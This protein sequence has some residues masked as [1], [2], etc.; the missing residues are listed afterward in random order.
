MPDGELIL[1]QTEDG[2]ARVQ[3]RAADGTVWLTQAEIAELFNVTPQNV[4]QHLRSLY[5]DGEVTEAA[6]C[7][8]YLQVRRE[9]DRD[10]Q[11]SLR[12]YNLDAILGIGY[13]VRSERGVQFRRWATTQLR[14]YLVKGFV[15]DTRRLSDPEPFDYFD[16]LLERIR[17]IRASE[18]RFYQKVCDLYSTASDY[19]GDSERAKAFFAAVQNKLEYAVT[20][21]TAPELIVARADAAKPNM[22]LT[23]WKGS[24]VRKGDVTT[25]KN[26]LLEEEMTRLNRIVSAYLDIGE[27]MASRRQAMTM[28]DWESR[29]D[30]YLRFLGLPVLQGGGKVSRAQADTVAHQRYERFDVARRDAER[31]AADAAAERDL[32]VIEAQAAR[33]AKRSRRSG[34][35][36]D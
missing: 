30:E 34:E 2:L 13:R 31:L 21:A 18:K 33:L 6:T 10:V 26:Y 19:N 32:K 9:G 15:I 3:L 29:V 1:Y 4:T 36:L 35:T 25:A 24:R 17:E 14:E 28:G 27:E 12:I 23:A 22:G 16:E 8:D 5:A 7:K 11:R 20:G